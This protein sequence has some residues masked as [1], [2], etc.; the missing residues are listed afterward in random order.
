MLLRDLASGIR[1]RLGHKAAAQEHASFSVFSP[2]S[3]WI[4][5][6][7]LNAERRYELRIASVETLAERTLFKNEGDGLVEPCA[8]SPDS[9][10]IL[11]LLVR[12][13]SASEIAFIAADTGAVKIVKR[14]GGEPPRRIDLSPDGRSIAYRNSLLAADGSRERRLVD[15]LDGDLSPV[16]S[17]DGRWV[18]LLGKDAGLWRAGVED[19]KPVLIRAGIGQAHL[20][21]TTR[22]GRLYLGRVVGGG[23]V[24]RA[25][26]D[27]GAG[28]LMSA[29]EADG[30]SEPQSGLA[31]VSGN[32]Q[33]RDKE[34]WRTG[35]ESPVATFP[36]AITALAATRDGETVA[37]AQSTT[38]TVISAKG[39]V[40]SRAAS[41]TI[42]GLVWTSDGQ[43]LIT[44]Q[45]DSLWW[46]SAS[47]ENFRRIVKLPQG[48]IGSV[49]LGPGDAAIFFTA[50]RPL[51]EVWS[52]A[53][54]AR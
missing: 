47:L 49:S 46:W 24:Y 7:W 21:G 27:A 19:R 52:I 14:L 30:E 48:S 50:G 38:L 28:K 25:K 36:R 22:E 12:G 20:R 13:P 43:H 45:N 4:A 39:R 42:S 11:A 15:G 18:F 51:S 6:T 17:R 1:L 3:K 33:A 16:F 41:E 29:P 40:E 8:F 34:L 32:Y 26:F 5:Y 31:V 53:V 37:V 23:N 35:G 2:D 10:Q 9:K 44:V 54:D